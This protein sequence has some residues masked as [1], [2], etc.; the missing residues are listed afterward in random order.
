MF[1]GKELTLSENDMNQL[2]HSNPESYVTYLL[3]GDYFKQIGNKNKA[4]E[5]FKTALTKEVASK[6]EENYLQGKIDK[7]Q[8]DLGL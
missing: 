7:L 3:L 8:D 5:H 4:L 6:S 2:I 1:F